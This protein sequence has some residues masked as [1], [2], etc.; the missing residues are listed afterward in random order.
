[1]RFA[2]YSVGEQVSYGI[3]DGD[4]VRDIDGTPFGDYRTTERVRPLS[5][6]KLLA[7]SEHP[8]HCSPRAS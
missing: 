7:P 4:N 8:Q 2:R 1:M 6:V 5:T 3:V